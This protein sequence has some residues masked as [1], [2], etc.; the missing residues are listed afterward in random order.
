MTWTLQQRRSAFEEQGNPVP[1]EGK[2]AK[3]NDWPDVEKDHASVITYMDNYVG[4]FIKKLQ[5]KDLDNNT[6]V[7][8]ASDNGAHNEGGHDFLYFNST[9][10]LRGHKRSMF[11]GGHR[12]PSLARW[13]GHVPAGTISDE[14]WAFW[15]VLPTLA[16]L[17]GVSR[18]KL[19]PNL[20]GRSILSTLLG[21]GRSSQN[22]LYF[23]G[24]SSWGDTKPVMISNM[25]HSG[26]KKTAYAILNG[27]WKGVVA[28]CSGT[29]T[30]NDKMQLFDLEVDPFETTNIADSYPEEV[31]A[32]KGIIASEDGISC[33]C[34]QC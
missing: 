16:D 21:K 13:P 23:T 5:K 1:T 24:A 11:E 14:Q 3:H 10:G 12:S 4:Q 33:K 32:L 30:F 28:S 2:Y 20:S 22:Y 6:I 7:I 27:K 29:P 34:F 25:A 17:A 15:D 18:N 9:G 19:P 8:F 31:D 26:N